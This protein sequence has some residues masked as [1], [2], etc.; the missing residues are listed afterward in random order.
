MGFQAGWAEWKLRTGLQPTVGCKELADLTPSQ[1]C[2][3][4]ALLSIPSGAHQN[5]VC[6]AS[7]PFINLLFIIL[8]SLCLQLYF[9]WLPPIASSF[10]FNCI[11]FFGY[12]TW[13]IFYFLLWSWLLQPAAFHIKCRVLFWDELP[14]RS[15]PCTRS[16]WPV[17]SRNCCSQECIRIHT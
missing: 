12:F 11:S 8:L 5:R 10:F 15:A 2:S 6:A 7:S 17:R 14:K 16:W 1:S 9:T 3:A 13:L 4:R